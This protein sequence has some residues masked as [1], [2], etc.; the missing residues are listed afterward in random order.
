V[1][2]AAAPV[3]SPTVLRLAAPLV[4][5]FAMRAAFTLVD[6]V[7][8]AILGDH[9]VA[10]IG[11][12]V[13]FEFVGIAIWV[14]LSTGLTSC[15]SRAMGAHQ[16]GKI[17]QYLR[18]GWIHAA[19]I[20]PVFFLLGL[21]IWFFFPGGRLSAEVLD[22]FR[23]YGFVLI[24][25]GAFTMFWSVIPDS[26]VKA[27]HDTRSTMWAGIWSNVINVVLNTFFLFVLEWGVFGIALSTVIGRIAGL[28]YALARARH[29][30]RRRKEAG[31]DNDPSLDPA[32]HRAVLGL[33]VPSSLTFVLMAGELAVI[34]WLLAL[35]EDNTQMLAAYSIYYRVLLFALNP[36]IA[37]AV[38][39][40]P[41]AA[42]RFGQGDLQGVRR[43]LREANVAA[44]LYS[45]LVVA[46]IM[47][48][49]SPWI[50]RSLGESPLTTEFATF[51]LWLTPLACFSAAPFLL[52]R[53]VFEGMHRGR[54]GLVV[55]IFRYVVLSVPIAWMGM[56]AARWFDRPPFHGLVVGLLLVSAFTSGAFYL[57]LRS[58]LPGND[59]LPSQ[60]S[61]G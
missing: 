45:F 10:A 8:A 60:E 11:I 28:A 34:N 18:A 22:A 49:G 21:W 33:A 41:Y 25:G 26:V 30:E 36:I 58:V 7:Y 37:V 16:G 29:H 44:I 23:V 27:H 32:P 40:L 51:A 61:A 50:A 47:L 9:A 42:R 31:Q 59:R 12:A 56:A 57:W 4:V 55:A 19:V 38:A 5:S 17:A 13:P 20:S 48:I 35:Q 14:G 15:L 54:P 46:P 52:C 3:P 2:C 39:L 6:T 43:G 24:G 53:P 1:T